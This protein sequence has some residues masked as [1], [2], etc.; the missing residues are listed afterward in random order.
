[1]QNI[2]T[3]FCCGYMESYVL[4]VASIGQIIF[5]FVSQVE[6]NF[7]EGVFGILQYLFFI[8]KKQYIIVK[9]KYIYNFFILLQ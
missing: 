4:L 5:I 2:D 1:M 3:S 7:F 9:Y 6:Q 8:V